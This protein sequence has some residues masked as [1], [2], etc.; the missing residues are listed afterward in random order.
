MNSNDKKSSKKQRAKIVSTYDYRN[1]E[2]ALLYQ[3][4]LYEPR[5][6]R[7]R[8]PKPDGD[9]YVMGIRGVEPVPYRLELWHDKDKALFYVTDEECVRIIEQIGLYGTCSHGGNTKFISANLKYFQG[10]VLIIVPRNSEEGRAHAKQLAE[11]VSSS[12]AS[13][14][15]LQIS[16]IPKGGTIADWFSAGGSKEELINISKNTQKY[17]D[18]IDFPKQELPTTAPIP[19]EE[20]DASSTDKG[21]GNSQ[22]APLKLHQQLP[23][24]SWPLGHQDQNG[25]PLNTIENMQYMLTAYG[26]K[27]AYDVIKKDIIVK[28]PGTKFSTAN[29]L[30]CSLTIIHS[31][32]QLNGLK[33]ENADPYIKLIADGNQ[34]NPVHDWIYAKPPEYKIDHLQAFFDTIVTKASFPKEMKDLLLRKWMISACAALDMEQGYIGKAVLVFQGDQGIGKTSWIR[35]L[36]PKEFIEYVKEDVFL[37]PS[38]KDSLSKTLSHWIVE[39]GELDGNL[40]KTDIARLKG[41]LSSSVDVFRRPYDRKDSR[42]SRKTCFFATVNPDCFLVDS[43]GNA[44]F[45]TIP[46]IELKEHDLDMQQVWAE[47][48]ALYCSGENWWL[49]P[50]QDQE[51]AK[52]N[53]EHEEVSPIEELV[54]KW[55]DL[56][57]N[58][59]RKLTAT[60]VLIEIGMLNC[61]QSD[62]N[63]CGKILR[64]YFGKPKRTKNRRVYNMPHMRDANRAQADINSPGQQTT[65]DQDTF[66]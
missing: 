21:A 8:K 30:N 53:K 2:G 24:Y 50:K 60:E 26:I 19:E 15:I 49:D 10:K 33:K 40:R 18:A 31:L 38:N 7:Q 44:R 13:V 14:R 62:V 22:P 1:A 55:Y 25:K 27:P 11:R 3:S 39:L 63:E 29:E 42:Y 35:G 12:A 32:C 45:W 56:T 20:P 65:E 43:T 61:K 66:L 57:H 9:G 37:D 51:L 23:K 36:V 47:A 46:V 16:E 48:F 54:L 17:S 4:V 64:K 52:L 5:N 6:F 41:F 59:L 34:I 58:R 28:I